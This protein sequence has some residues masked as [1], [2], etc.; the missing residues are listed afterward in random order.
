MPV[1]ADLVPVP[2]TVAGRV[3]L[4]RGVLRSLLIRGLYGSQ[5]QTLAAFRARDVGWLGTRCLMLGILVR[6]FAVCISEKAI[7]DHVSNVP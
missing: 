4:N 7:Q 5:K 3:R 6:A 1:V 2:V